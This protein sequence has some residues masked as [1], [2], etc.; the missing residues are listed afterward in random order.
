MINEGIQSYN[1]SVIR[2]SNGFVANMCKAYF[3][4]LKTSNRKEWFPKLEAYL[5]HSTPKLQQILKTSF[6]IIMNGENSGYSY[7]SKL[8]LGMILMQET[9]FITLAEELAIYYGESKKEYIA[10]CFKELVEG[11][12]PEYTFSTMELFQKQLEKFA[13]KVLNVN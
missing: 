2:S 11:I 5:I 13:E 12:Q 1:L 3:S 8:I 7:L 4:Q 10:G 6:V 9:Y